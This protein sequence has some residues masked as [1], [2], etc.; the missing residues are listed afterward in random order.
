MRLYLEAAS[1]VTIIVIEVHKGT[2]LIMD[3]NTMMIKRGTMAMA[4][5]ETIPWWVPAAQCHLEANG[6]LSRL[7]N[8]AEV[9]PAP[10]VDI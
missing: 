5:L 10:V 7:L 2:L 8:K 6:L 1:L 9:R 3:N 4:A